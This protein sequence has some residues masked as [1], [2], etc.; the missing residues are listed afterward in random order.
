[1][2]EEIRN[3]FKSFVGNCCGSCVNYTN[4]YSEHIA[5]NKKNTLEHPS[6]KN[7]KKKEEN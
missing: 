6:C 1:M 4:H 5:Y 3:F 7:F 2:K